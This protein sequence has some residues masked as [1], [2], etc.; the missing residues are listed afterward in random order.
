MVGGWLVGSAVALVAAIVMWPYFAR[1]RITEV[2]QQVMYAESGAISALWTDPPAKVEIDEAVAEVG[3]C[4]AGLE[5]LYAGQLRRP[6]S[7]Y[8]RERTFLRLVEEVRR[9]RLGLRSQWRQG[10]DPS[11]AADRQLAGSLRQR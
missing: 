2:V 4:T 8:R 10:V 5:A 11:F 1:A 7:A 6:G 9:L 3:D